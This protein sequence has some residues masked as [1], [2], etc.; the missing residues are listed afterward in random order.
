MSAFADCLLALMPFAEEWRD[1]DPALT[2]RDV[3]RKHAP[4]Q[5]CSG[6]GRCDLYTPKCHAQRTQRCED[7]MGAGW[8]PG[9]VAAAIAMAEERARLDADLIAAAERWCESSGGSVEESWA[10]TRM[11][12]AY[13]ERAGAS[14][15]CPAC[16]EADCDGGGA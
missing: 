8:T 5:I 15:G 11:I 3:L 13:G 6:L 10:S 12:E 16:G 4:C 2:A 9:S 14:T 7:C 1:G